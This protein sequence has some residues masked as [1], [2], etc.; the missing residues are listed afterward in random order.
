VCGRDCIS[1]RRGDLGSP[2]DRAKGK[3]RS[4]DGP[5]HLEQSSKFY[6]NFT[7][8]NGLIALA[9]KTLESVEQEKWLI[10]YPF[11]SAFPLILTRDIDAEEALLDFGSARTAYICYAAFHAAMHIGFALINLIKRHLVSWNCHP[12]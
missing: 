10:R 6:I 12:L 5:E 3:P 7:V 9:D 2:T 4:G 8:G 1:E 11:I